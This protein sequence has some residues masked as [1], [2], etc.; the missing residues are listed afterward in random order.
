MLALA[1][2]LPSLVSTPVSYRLL[3]CSQYLSYAPDAD[4]IKEAAAEAD[5][6]IHASDLEV[7]SEVETAP[8]DAD[9]GSPVKK[10]PNKRPKPAAPREPS[11]TAK[12]LQVCLHLPGIQW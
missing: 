3:S 1:S 10:K 9:D 5:D 4:T 7:D 12:Q 6:D 11:A 2:T 8:S